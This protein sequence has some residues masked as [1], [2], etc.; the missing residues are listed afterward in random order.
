MPKLGFRPFWSNKLLRTARQGTGN[1]TLVLCKRSQLLSHLCSPTNNSKCQFF[2]V[3]FFRD[4]V[5]LCS[6]GCPGTHFVDQAGLELR[7]L[8]ASA[9]RVLGLKGSPHPAFKCQF[10]MVLKQEY[11]NFLLTAIT[12]PKTAVADGVFGSWSW[13]SP[14]CLVGYLSY[15]LVN[16]S[17]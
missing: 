7:N 15:S 14:N 3:L 17:K 1:Q 9:S 8:P 12:N 16:C 6:P 11:F 13:A 10:L 2:F 4:R 5:S